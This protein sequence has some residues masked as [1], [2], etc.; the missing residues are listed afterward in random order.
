MSRESGLGR[1]RQ[2]SQ[3]V[4]DLE[5]AVHFY[6]EL[7]GLR[8]I[9]RYGPLAFFDMDGTRLYLQES[10]GDGEGSVLYFAV[11]DLDATR[12][13][14]ESRGVSFTDDP[15]VIFHDEAGAFGPAGEDEWMTFFRDSEGNLL[16]LSSRRAPA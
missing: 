3:H 9:A 1:L 6:G 14:L 15:H 2:V 5:R 7:L 16:A 13:G 4:G 12:A 11:D 8:L 10:E